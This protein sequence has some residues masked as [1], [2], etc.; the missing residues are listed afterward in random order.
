MSKKKLLIVVPHLST[1]GLPQYTLKQAQE[2]KE[3]YDITVCEVN[4]YGHEYVVQRKQII[5]GCNFFSLMGKPEGLIRIIKE[6]VRPDVIHFQEIPE[7]FIHGNILLQIFKEDRPYK[8]VCT[9]HGS[10]TD[11]AAISFTPDHF[12]L[13][14]RWS[15]QQFEKVFPGMCSVWEYPIERRRVIRYRKGPLKVLNV[16]LFTPGKNQ[17]EVFSV[18]RRI[19]N[20]SFSFVGNMAPNFKSY[21]EPLV[22]DKP[23]NCTLYGERDDVDTFYYS[24]DLL[25]FPSKL[26]LNPLVVREALGWQ[27]PI[28]MYRL[29]T[30]LDDYDKYNQPLVTFIKDQDEAYRRIKHLADARTNSRHT[31]D[32]T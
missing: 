17:A 25:Y 16:G 9:T 15:E 24:H 21:W 30:Y 11:P 8:I 13:V 26:E 2:S 31:A 19:P 22:Q 12:V 27:L 7:T 18:A 23:M 6:E 3:D 10:H 32:R 29:P 20:A 28:L 5:S 14:N 1:G 4:F